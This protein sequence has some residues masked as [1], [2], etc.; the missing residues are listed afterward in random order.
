MKTLTSTL[1]TTPAQ[2][3]EL[4][5]G[6]VHIWKADLHRI[7]ALGPALE[8]TLAPEESRRAQQ[9]SH[10]TARHGY[11]LSCAVRRDILAGYLNAKPSELE[12]RYGAHGK[13]ELA[14][15]AI[16]FNVTHSHRLAVCAVSKSL[17]VGVDVERMQAGVEEEISG[18]FFSSRAIRFLE[19]LPPVRRQRTFF[20]GW[21]RMEA[22]AKALGVGLTIDFENLEALLTA[23]GPEFHGAGKPAADSEMCWLHDFQPRKGYVAALAVRGGECKVKYWKWQA[24]LEPSS[25]R[26]TIS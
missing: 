7:L 24:T 2:P 19:S 15:R 20:Q 21:T 22:Y 23:S 26:R 11:M 14:D 1:W 16:H 10:G 5:P 3:P 18:W 17:Q 4:R 25:S 13:P 9:F 8:R 12:F 6:E